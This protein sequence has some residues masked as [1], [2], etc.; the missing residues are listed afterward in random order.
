M[1]DP[2][3]IN[4][5]KHDCSIIHEIELGFMISKEAKE[6]EESKW[7]DYI[8]GYFLVFDFTEKEM[9]ADVR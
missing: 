9:L 6:I 4:L 5:P 7:E 1:K 2:T 8:A 3:E